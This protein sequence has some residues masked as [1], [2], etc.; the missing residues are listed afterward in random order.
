V[1]GTVHWRARVRAGWFARTA[2]LEAF[3]AAKALPQCRPHHNRD[4]ERKL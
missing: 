1:C 3:F 4:M 2:Q